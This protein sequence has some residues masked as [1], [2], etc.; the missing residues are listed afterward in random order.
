MHLSFINKTN[1][2]TIV[3]DNEDKPFN[4]I[5]AFPTEF[6]DKPLINDDV[7]NLL[8]LVQ[9]LCKKNHLE[10]NRLIVLTHHAIPFPGRKQLNLAQASISALLKTLENEYPLFNFIQIDGPLENYDA[11]QSI[12]NLQHPESFYVFHD[13]KFY[14]PRLMMEHSIPLLDKNQW[15]LPETTSLEI[16]NLTKGAYLITGGL[17]G[18]GL[19]VANLLVSQ[20][21]TTLWL[22]SRHAPDEKTLSKLKQITSNQTEIITQQCDVG[23]RQSLEQLFNTIQAYPDPLV[24]IFHL[25]GQLEDSTLSDQNEEHIASVWHAKAKGAWYLHDLS[26][27]LSLK[28]FV[29]FSSIASVLGSAGQANYAMANS[30]LDALANYRQQLRLPA[31]SINWGPWQEIGMTVN[32]QAKMEQL[33]I[34]PFSEKD[35]LDALATILNKPYAQIAALNIN[36]T[37]LAKTRPQLP[38]WLSEVAKTN[39]EPKGHLVLLLEK[40]SVE[41]R[42]QVLTEELS[43]LL[44]YTLGMAEN[45]IIDPQEG[46]FNLGMDSLTAV[47]LRNRLQVALGNNYPLSAAEIFNYP[48]LDKLTQFVAS[49]IGLQGLAHHNTSPVLNTRVT[50]SNEPIAVIGMS[51]RFPGGADNPDQFWQLLAAGY[52]GISQIPSERWNVDDYYDADPSTPGKMQVRRGGFLTQSIDCFD[53][54]FFK[55]SPRQAEM[56]DPQQRILLEVTYEA[57]EDANIIP[58]TLKGSETGVFV[59]IWHSDYADLLA[60]YGSTEAINQ[61]TNGTTLSGTAGILSFYFGLMGPSYAVDTACSSSLVALD[62]A[63]KAL[64]SGECQ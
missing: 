9:A 60:K 62:G 58:S 6:I 28:H 2:E 27:N 4:I 19:T 50:S 21:A 33:G 42:E 11:L 57:L 29:L 61:F 44:K 10:D 40:T 38:A 35:G 51:C 55:I 49:K 36:W 24:G 56:M 48:A 18:L 41:D 30:Y 43:R 31:I 37:R 46:F 7:L 54:E 20:G 63:I 53:A 47:E 5:Y 12:L 14:V 17:G 45:K 25:A 13:Q 32:L 52:D 22:V 8:T 59:G 64:Q 15:L 39:I 23:D 3:K 34:E 16:N 1:F 26:K